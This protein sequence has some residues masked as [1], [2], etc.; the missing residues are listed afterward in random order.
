[1]ALFDLD[2]HVSVV[3]G[4]NSGIGLGMA[5]GLAESGAQVVIWGSS[6]ARNEAAVAQLSS[7]GA[8]AQMTVDVSDEQQVTD[9]MAEV[10]SRYGRLDS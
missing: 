8:V 9:A 6:A 1:M 3:T 2:G 7:R 10:A 5:G 4:G